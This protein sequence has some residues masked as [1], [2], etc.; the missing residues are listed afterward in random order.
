[1][2]RR[3]AGDDADTKTSLGSFVP[4]N[5]STSGS[6]PASD[7]RHVHIRVVAGRHRYVDQFERGAMAECLA[8]SEP[9]R[10]C[11]SACSRIDGNS[12]DAD[13]VERRSEIR[14]PQPTPAESDRNRV[15]DGEAALVQLNGQGA[16]SRHP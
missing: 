10:I 15:P 4:A 6:L 2:N 16:G 14:G 1:M 5:A 8:R 12:A 13:A 3:Q 9:G 11:P 7:A